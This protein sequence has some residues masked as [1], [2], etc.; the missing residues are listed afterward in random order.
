MVRW[1]ESQA[2]RKAELRLAL[3]RGRV[4]E[5]RAAGELVERQRVEGV[6]VRVYLPEES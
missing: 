6:G 4:E 1:R 5:Q 2:I 3:A